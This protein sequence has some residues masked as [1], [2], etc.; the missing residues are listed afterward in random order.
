MRSRWFS[1]RW[2]PLYAP[3]PP[4]SSF[5]L[6]NVLCSPGG[7]GGGGGGEDVCPGFEAPGGDRRARA[8]SLRVRINL[9]LREHSF[10]PSFLVAPAIDRA[11]RPAVHP[12]RHRRGFLQFF[13]LPL[14]PRRHPKVEG[15]RW[16]GREQ[17]YS[18][19]YPKI[20][21]DP[22]RLVTRFCYTFSWLFR[23]LVVSY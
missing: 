16:L 9:C 12:A 18:V 14:P 5:Q 7:G 15:R 17:G 4:S 11:S 2:S 10:L 20:Q 3:S 1:V 13:T 22:S 8:R 21:R 23:Q 6:Q 19:A